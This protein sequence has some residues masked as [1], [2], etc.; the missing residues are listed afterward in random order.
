MSELKGST[1]EVY[2]DYNY[3]TNNS[4]DPK[5]TDLLNKNIEI[6]NIAIRHKYDMILGCIKF[7]QIKKNS[8]STVFRSIDVNYLPLK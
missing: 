3:T 6:G 1:L 5:L 4:P 7:E 8:Y 2:I